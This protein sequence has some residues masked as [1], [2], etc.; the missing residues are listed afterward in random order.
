M[1]GDIANASNWPDADVYVAPLGTSLPAT[2]DDDF[3]AGWEL[4]GLL[5][6]ETGFPEAREEEQN[7]FYAWGG[8]LVRRVRRNFKLTKSFTALEDNDTTWSLIWPG[9]DP[10]EVVVPRP[11]NLLVAFEVREGEK[12]KRLITA[13]Y[14]QVDVV[15]E[16]TD[17]ESNITRYELAATIFPDSTTSPPKLFEVQKTTS[18]S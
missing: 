6:G 18:G 16:I 9:S 17:N 1:S 2:V 11:E 3:P 4:V 13:N 8:T 14:A 7:D 15:G 12:V 10:D 5:D